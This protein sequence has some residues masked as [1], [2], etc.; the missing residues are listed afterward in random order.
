M[1]DMLN[2][3]IHSAYCIWL[4]SVNYCLLSVVQ[5]KHQQIC[6]LALNNRMLT[7]LYEDWFSHKTFSHPKILENF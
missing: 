4:D 1:N 2:I 5:W 3:A 7:M 6:S